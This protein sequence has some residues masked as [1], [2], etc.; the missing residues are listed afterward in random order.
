M[1]GINQPTRGGI[2]PAIVGLKLL[3]AAISMNMLTFGIAQMV[4]PLVAQLGFG[5][6]Y[7]IDVLTCGAAAWS[8]YK[9]PSLPPQGNRPPGRGSNP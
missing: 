4:G 9:L 6:T 7:S 2:I 8:V 5:W 3:P 1:G